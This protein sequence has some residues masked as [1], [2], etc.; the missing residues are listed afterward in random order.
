MVEKK[1]L[2]QL[3]KS[4]SFVYSMSHGNEPGGQPSQ[5]M[6]TPLTLKEMVDVL[7]THMGLTQVLALASCNQ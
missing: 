7:D 4:I 3:K 5:S 2:S 1:V 6:L